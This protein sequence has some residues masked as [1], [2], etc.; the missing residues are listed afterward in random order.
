MIIKLTEAEMVKIILA[1]LEEWGYSTVAETAEI[2]T[3]NLAPDEISYSFEVGLDE[4]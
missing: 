3:I 2:T 4:N 1:Y